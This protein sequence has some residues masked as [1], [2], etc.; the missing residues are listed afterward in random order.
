MGMAWI[1]FA[2]ATAQAAEA[3][4]TRDLAVNGR[5]D[6]TVATGAGTIHLTAG[7]AGHVHVFGRVKSGWG[8]GE[9]DVQRVAANPPIQQTGNIVRV[10]VR[11]E[12]LN[13][14]SIDYDIQAP[15]DSYL[16]ASSGSGGVNDIGVGTKAKLSAGS[17]SIHATGLQGGFAVETGSGSIYAE[18]AGS[19]DVKAEAGSGSIELKNV[20]GGLHAE[21]GSGSIKADGLPS[22]RWRLETGSGSV[23]IW[24]GAA[25]LALDATSGSGAIHC[26]REMTAAASNQHHHL[27]GKIGGGGPLVRIVTGSGSIDIH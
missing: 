15:A 20:H 17:G 19:G 18:Q 10:G 23:E 3:T 1:V 9:A 14:I 13:N 21:T 5:V 8:R 2:A 16:D 26:D 12:M 7:P 11:S 4:F 24:T 27:A 6:L 25:P 22:A